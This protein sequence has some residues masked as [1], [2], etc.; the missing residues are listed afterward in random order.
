MKSN[1]PLPTYRS[2]VIRRTL[3]NIFGTADKEYDLPIEIRDNILSMFT[4][5]PCTDC[6]QKKFCDSCR[7]GRGCGQFQEW[8]SITEKTIKGEIAL[9]S[10]NQKEIKESL[11]SIIAERNRLKLELETIRKQFRMILEMPDCNNC[12][13]K[14]CQYRPKWGENIR[15]NCPL[16][17]QSSESV[18]T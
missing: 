11:N 16:W 10:L 15:I 5:F 4:K 3:N 9:A 13:N 7:K 18:N 17:K 14:N 12:A 8:D 1:Q 2:D 6:R